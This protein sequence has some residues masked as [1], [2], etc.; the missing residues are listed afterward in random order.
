MAFLIYRSITTPDA[1]VFSLYVP[2]LG[3]CHDLTLL[4]GSGLDG[5]L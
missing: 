3:R 5:I 2:E 1:L 4:R